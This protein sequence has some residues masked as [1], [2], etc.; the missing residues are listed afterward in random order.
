MKPKISEDG[1][2]WILAEGASC[3]DFFCNFK[4]D[5]SRTKYKKIECVNKVINIESANFNGFFTPNPDDE[6]FLCPT[7]EEGLCSARFSNKLK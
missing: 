2:F 7:L 5:P 3:T 6:K 1:K 4:H